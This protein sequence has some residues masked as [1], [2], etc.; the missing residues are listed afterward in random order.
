MEMAS[1][2]VGAGW[3][4]VFWWRET[5]ADLAEAQFIASI[6]EEYPILSLGI[7]VEKGRATA[8][9]N[10]PALDPTWD[11]RNLLRRLRFATQGR[12]QRDGF[13]NRLWL[14]RGVSADDANQP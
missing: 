11:W 7:S 10:R 6:S 4:H 3:R 2:P 14:A 5:E 8:T 12:Q 13:G 1:Y 9:K